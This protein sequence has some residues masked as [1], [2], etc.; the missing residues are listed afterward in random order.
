MSIVRSLLGRSEERDATTGFLLPF[1]QWVDYFNYGN[2][3]YPVAPTQTLVGDHEEVGNDFAGFVAGAFKANAPVFALM[4]CR[5]RHFAEARFMF[6]DRVS[7][8]LVGGPGLA[9]L[10]R[11]WLNGTTGDLMKRMIQDV[12]L[13][14]N[15]YTVR[16]GDHLGRL[17]P[18]WV[19]IVLGSSTKRRTW[20]A[21][22]PDTVVIA[23]LYKPGGGSSGAA[24]IPYRPEQVAHFAPIPDPTGIFRGMSWLTP[25]I[26]EIQGDQAAAGHKVKFFQNGAT[27]N[28]VVK[29]PAANPELFDRWVDKLEGSH[30]GIANAYKTV[31]L[32]AGADMTAIG[33]DMAQ[34]DFRAVV[35]AGEN[36]LASAAGVHPAIVGFTDSLQGSSLNA[37]NLEALYRIFVEGTLKNLWREAAGALETI[38]DKPNGGLELWYD[39]R[40]VGFAQDNL[41]DVGM[42][43]KLQAEALSL[44]FMAGWDPDASVA[45][46][47]GND[48]GL[49][50]GKHTGAE[51]V[52]TQQGSGVA[53]PNG[54][55]PVMPP[56]MTPAV[57]KG[58]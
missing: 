38:V 50:I 40:D 31:Y 46:L 43:A 26:R 56:V 15:S 53:P 6:R 37:G 14:G 45:W 18:D 49:L 52:Q 57:P 29:I 25:L 12:D 42:V 28:H 21:G 8:K 9:L 13:V 47:Q 24:P 55:P 5:M 20:V 34:I 39:L 58:K 17:R 7:H 22:D 4:Q 2:V 32:G 48:L 19:N 33:S 51:S 44:M 16:E 30:A 35:G 11:P 54:K 10:D 27:V 3:V 36:R 23:Y 1:Q 41:K